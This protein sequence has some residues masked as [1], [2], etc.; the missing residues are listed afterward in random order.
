MTSDAVRFA[1]AAL[2]IARKEVDVEAALVRLV[3]D[4]SVVGGE[5]AVAL[6]LGGAGDAIGISLIHA[7]GCVRSVKHRVGDHRAQRVS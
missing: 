7:A 1:Q 3:D 2:E 5:S 4:N 6:R